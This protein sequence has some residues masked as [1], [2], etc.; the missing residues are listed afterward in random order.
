L[1][2]WCIPLLAV[3]WP[4]SALAGCGKLRAS[5]LDTHQVQ[6]VCPPCS[7]Y[8]GGVWYVG[9]GLSSACS[10]WPSSALARR[11]K[12]WGLDQSCLLT[13]I[14]FRVVVG[15][16]N[17]VCVCGMCVH[18]ACSALAVISSGATRIV[19]SSLCRVLIRFSHYACLPDLSTTVLVSV[20]WMSSC[21]PDLYS[22]LLVS[23]TVE[24]CV[25][26]ACS[27]WPSSAL[28]RRGEA[29]S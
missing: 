28:A 7:Y 18:P 10:I 21:L 5:G 17:R 16:W 9:W 8:A 11:G 25:P 24:R 29:A 1:V 4:S 3:L 2:D 27:F 22:S 20:C 15:M 26:P 12:L 6:S 13:F 19:T 14:I 23:G